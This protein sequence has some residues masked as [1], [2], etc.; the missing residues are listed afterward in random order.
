MYT[1]HV[2]Y[3]LRVVPAHQRVI[4]PKTVFEGIRR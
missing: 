2:T 4:S 3:L 1:K